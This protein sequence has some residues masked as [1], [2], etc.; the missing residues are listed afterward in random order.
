VHM[1]SSPLPDAIDLGVAAPQ[2]TRMEVL[3]PQ[4]GGRLL[5]LNAFTGEPGWVDV[6]GVGPVPADDGLPAVLP[7]LDAG[8]PPPEVA[9]VTSTRATVTYV[10]Q[11]GDWLK[12][13]A[14]RYGLSLA[15]L[16]AANP[17]ANPDLISIGLQLQLPA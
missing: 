6:S 13:I 1:W 2:F 8:L 9:G 14:A 11:Q 12:H 17:M 7:V 4:L 10:V 16:L 3:A 5:V 15:A